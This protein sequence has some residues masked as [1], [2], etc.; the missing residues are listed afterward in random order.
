[1]F[2]QVYQRRYESRRSSKP[3]LHLKKIKIKYGEKR[4]SLA[5][6]GW[7]SYTLQ[8]GTIT[9]LISSGDCTLQCGMWLWNRD[10]E[11]TKWQ[12]PAMW[13]LA[14][15][16]HAIEFAQT[17]A[18]LEFYIWFPFPYITTVDMS[19][20]TSL[21]NFIQIR[22]PSAEK[23]TSCRFSIWCISAILDCRDPIMGSLKSPCTTSYRSSIDT[24]AVNCLVLEKKSFFCILATDRQTD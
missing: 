9:T 4:F 11:F 5:Y 7:N 22:P 13:H 24:I 3:K 23:M 12:H 20:C 18:M 14:V 17:S 19:F 1:V 2:Q 15:G 21:R 8:C 16:W 6:A 10:S